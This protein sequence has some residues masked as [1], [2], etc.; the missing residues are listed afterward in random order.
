MLLYLFCALAAVAVFCVLL[1]LLAPA[2]T[3]R[4]AVRRRIDSLADDP[5]RKFVLDDELNQPL[6]ERFIKPTL[7]SVNEVFER[8]MRRSAKNAGDAREKR[9]RQDERLRKTIAQAGLAFSVD[10]FKVLRSIIMAAAFLVGFSAGAVAR[11][12][13]ADQLL[14]GIVGAFAAFTAVRY[15]LAALATAR[16]RKM[17]RQLP[18]ILDILSISVEAGLGFEQA[19]QH[20]TQNMA[21]PMVDEFNVACREIS[22]GRTRREALQALAE[23]CEIEELRTFTGA[24]IQAGQLGISIKNVLRSQSTAMRQSRRSKAE[25]KAHKVSTKILI[26]M[27]LF[28]FPVLFIVLLGPAVMNILQN[29][30]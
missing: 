15:V 27:L 29:L 6:F 24:V 19:L 25:E 11:R 5:R 28:I 14:F 26:P 10:N 22:M 3:R 13:V 23:R 20:I 17:E 12:P 18:D 21:G 9:N 8:F 1:A 30:R 16:K 2:G 7:E 4:D